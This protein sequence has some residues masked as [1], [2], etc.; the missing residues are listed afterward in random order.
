MAISKICFE[1]FTVFEKIEIDFCDGINV[2]I[3]ENGTGKTLLTRLTNTD[4]CKAPQKVI[5]YRIGFMVFLHSRQLI[6]VKFKHTKV[7]DYC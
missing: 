1:N 6:R 5:S 2:V 3:G 7:F 4:K